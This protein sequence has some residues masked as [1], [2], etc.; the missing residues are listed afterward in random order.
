[1]ACV[2]LLR[3]RVVIVPC[4]R[5]NFTFLIGTEDSSE[6]AVVDP[7]EPEPVAQALRTQGLR[8][9]AI[10]NTHHH[11]DHVG[12]NMRVLQEFPGIDVYA[13]S[14]DRGRIPGQTRYLN[15]GDA[16]HVAGLQFR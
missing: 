4:L 15:E 16:V 2:S 14:S 9:V 5:D 10:L 1:M 13:H 11:A 7:S 3:M 8:A 6:V 12:G